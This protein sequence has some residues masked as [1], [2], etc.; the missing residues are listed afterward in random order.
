MVQKLNKMF[1][2]SREEHGTFKYLGVRFQQSENKIVL[3]Q[4]G[5]L[6]S[7]QIDLI[8]RQLLKE[9]ERYA[10]EEEKKKFRQGVGQLGWLEGTTQ[11]QVGFNFCQLSTVQSNP[12]M[13]DFALYSKVVKELKTASALILIPKVDL[14]TQDSS[15]Q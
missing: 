2:I 14:E 15:I 13:K 7:L 12:Q 9:K 8:E 5:Y 4:K 10:S 3:E 11:P 1:K 6:E